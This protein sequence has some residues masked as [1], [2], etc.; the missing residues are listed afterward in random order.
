MEVLIFGGSGFIG[1]HLAEGLEQTGHRCWIATRGPREVRH[2]TCIRYD[3]PHLDNLLK[4]FTGSDYAVVNLLGESLAK[5]RWTPD[6]KNRILNSRVEFTQALAASIRQIPERPLVLLNAS[7]IGYY[8]N[9]ETA[10]FTESSPPGEGFLAQVAQS[11][12]GA[13][14]V[15]MSATRVVFLRLGV[16]LGMDGGALPTMITPYRWFAGGNLGTGR[17]WVSWIHIQD[18]VNLALLS[19]CNSSLQGPMNAVSP[20]PVLMAEFGRTLARAMNQPHWLPIPAVVVR[21]L[22]GEMSSM[23]LEGQHVLPEQAENSGYSFAY[24]HLSEALADLLPSHS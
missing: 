17:Q 4:R 16:V 21:L 3:T 12:E 7:A 2:G 1:Q 11:W 10:V 18:V 5:R 22:L 8:G 24:A 6:Q 13:A 20:H 14:A 15:A 19:L 23:I 9:S